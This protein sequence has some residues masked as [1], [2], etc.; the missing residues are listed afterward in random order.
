MSWFLGSLHVRSRGEKELLIDFFIELIIKR[1]IET[2][3]FLRGLIEISREKK[4]NI[5]KPYPLLLYLVYR[6]VGRDKIMTR[7]EI[8]IAAS[9]IIAEKGFHATSMQEI[10]EA[11][12]L[13]KAS[14]YHHVNSK[15]EILVALLDMA[16]EMLI[17]QMQD[18]VDQQLPPKEKFKLAMKVYLGTLIENRELSSVL[19]LEH[20]SLAANLHAHHVP[21]RDKFET[22]WRGII[23]EGVAKK[24]FYSKNTNLAIKQVLGIAN[25]TIM[26]FDPQGPMTVDEISEKNAELLLNGF[27]TPEAGTGG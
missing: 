21:K 1:I 11:V 15:Q 19:L 22:L 6:P 25:W 14:L 27:T 18:V 26:W 16:L 20:R 13:R 12:D 4:H 2:V 7:D 17:E 23:D 5:D 3:E 10:A 24:V 8:L 9:Q